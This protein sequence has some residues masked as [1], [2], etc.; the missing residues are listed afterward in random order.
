MFQFHGYGQRTFSNLKLFK[1]IFVTFKKLEKLSPTE[2]ELPQKKEKKRIKFDYFEIP[3]SIFVILYSSLNIEYR[4]M[5]R[6]R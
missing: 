2:S 6:E 5:N 1:R 3:C 4:I